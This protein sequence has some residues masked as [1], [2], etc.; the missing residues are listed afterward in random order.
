MRK[1]WMFLILGIF[2]TSFVFADT[3]FFEGDYNYRDDFI[4]GNLTREVVEETIKIETIKILPKG[5]S[6]FQLNKNLV[7]D[8]CFDSLKQHIK[9]YQNIDYTEEQLNY[10]KIKIEEETGVYFSHKQ[11]AVLVE[12]FEDECNAQYPLLGG[13]AAGRYQNL[14]NPLVI[15][16]SAIILISLILLYIVFRKITKQK[17][18]KS[19]KKKKK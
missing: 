6:S 17:K 12:N 16:I 11:V 15:L 13:L 2:L 14:L 18:K 5:G 10:L 8:I 19:R 3:T 9:K 4:M 1:I 7:C